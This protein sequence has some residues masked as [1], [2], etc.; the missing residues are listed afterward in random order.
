M[1][2]KEFQ[3]KYGGEIINGRLVF[4]GYAYFEGCTSLTSIPEG[5]V[6]NGYANFG[7][8]SLDEKSKEYL[9]KIGK[10]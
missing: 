5:T 8:C 2:Q 1:T 6:F 7:G 9:R 3:K 4:N 10:I